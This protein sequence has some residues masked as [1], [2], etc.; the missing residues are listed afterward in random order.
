MTEAVASI[1]VRNLTKH[2]GKV[3][4]IHDV[5][6]KVMPGEI[7]G[8]L[9]P[10]GAGKTTTM[11]ILCGITPA[12]S[13]EAYIGGIP[14]ATAIAAIKKNI[15]YMPENN[16]LPEELRVIEYLKYRARLKGIP[17]RD[18]N[19]R[20]EEVLEICDLHRK[21]S[22]R[23]IRTL[24]KGYRQRVGVADAIL[25]NPEVIILD[26]PTIGLDPHQVLMIRDLIDHLR[27]S[28]T[29]IIS[30]HILAEVEVCCDRVIIINQ[31]RVVAI[32]N[33]QSLR[34]EFAD[35]VI[36]LLSVR[37][38][39]QQLPE[40]LAS[41]DPAMRAGDPEAMDDSGFFKIRIT[42]P[43]EEERGEALLARLHHHS[44]LEVRAL[45]RLETSLEDI[46]LAATKRSWDQETPPRRAHRNNNK[47]PS[48]PDSPTR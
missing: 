41:V 8:F 20:V 14:V 39:L 29:V 46:F 44:N 26:E 15:G 12:S 13:G 42:T 21:T 22:R 45:Q 2:Y 48:K 47:A 43:S 36:Y 32:G 3:T 17:R 19:R 4:A 24:S 16:P 25:A 38:N 33:A 10:N 28:M 1:H 27:G 6:F 11:R 5:T 40:V 31:G 30:S 37:G 23:M 18:R 35:E 9:G 7:V 34:T